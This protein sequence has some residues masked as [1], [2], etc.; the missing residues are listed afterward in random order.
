M[1][2]VLKGI[3]GPSDLKGLSIE[4]LEQL[5]DEIR[6]ELVE[7]VHKTGGHLSSNLGVVELT[8]GLHKVFDSPKDQL[9]WDV[10]HQ[11]YVHKML[12]G[13]KELLH[14]IRQE[15]GLSGFTKRHES[16]HDFFDVGHSSTSISAALGYATARDIK[17]HD[18]HVVAIIG[19][20]SMTA[21]M[22]F[23]A[24]NNGARMKSNFIVVLNDNQMSIS[25]NVGGM[26]RYLDKIRTGN[27]Y[28]GIKKDVHKLLDK[29]PVVGA[30]ITKA[31]KDLKDALKQI[32]IPGMFFEEMG[33]TYLGPVDGH[34]I[35][36]VLTVLEQAKRIQGPVLVHVNT[37]KGKG[38][39]KAEADPSKYHGIKAEVA[40][41][42]S[43]V[44]P[45][46]GKLLGN[47]LIEYVKNDEPIVAITAAMPTG[48]GL[49]AMAKLYPDSVVDVGIAEQHAVTYAA[50]LA[51]GGIKP[52]VAIYSSFLQRAY[53]Q[54]LHDVCIQNAPVVFLLDRAGIVGEDGETHQ[55]VFDIAYLNHM[56]NM[57]IMA[58]RDGLMFQSMLDDTLKHVHG[59]IAIRYPKGSC[60]LMDQHKVVGMPEAMDGQIL[61]QGKK[62]ALLGV[63]S[64]CQV[65]LEAAELSQDNWTVVDPIVM[66]P[67]SD[68]LME[69]I[70][71]DHGVVVVIE[72]GAVIG[73]YGQQ[74]QFYMANHYPEIK[75]LVI[76]LADKFIG[77]GKRSDILASC[78]LTAESVR[79]RIEEQ[80]VING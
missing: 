62:V 20:G 78:G 23:E 49:E 29:V 18:N 54:V 8:I 72:E 19:D 69:T 46:Y 32:M 24:L 14:T 9:I 22:A 38:Y 71:Q 45:S 15:G 31:A 57:Q 50:G 16:E 77:H 40:T 70:A 5:S 6:K 3:H 74:V 1:G 56:P 67:L 27:A 79:R 33:Y 59:P 11:S 7:T 80:V 66:K 4:S 17:G 42:S 28:R 36:E 25:K 64:M 47:R 35:E 65:A 76:G 37:T 2:S 55:G 44:K 34:N 73:G 61:I 60:P 39:E 58:P 53:D 10:G 41:K 52:Y 68:K 13:R 75:V 63:G 51:L 12:T 43:N 48:T 30:G 26:A 21:G